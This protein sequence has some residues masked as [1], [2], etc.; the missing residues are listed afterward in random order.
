MHLQTE[1]PPACECTY[2]GA[3]A[4][5]LEGPADWVRAAQHTW[6]AYVGEMV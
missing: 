4:A 6:A 5:G 3:L 2:V 1:V